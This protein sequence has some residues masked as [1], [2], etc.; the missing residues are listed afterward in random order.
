MRSFDADY[1]NNM[2]FGI[3]DGVCQDQKDIL[4]MQKLEYSQIKQINF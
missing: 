2:R 3:I 4:M 1:I